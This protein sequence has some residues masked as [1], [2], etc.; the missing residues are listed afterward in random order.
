MFTKTFFKDMAERAIK[1]FAQSFVAILLAGGTGLLDVD[2]VNAL[3]VAG[4]ALVVSVFTSVGSG[5][6]GDKSA[7]A[8][9][10]NKEGDN[11]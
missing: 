6:V 8:V 3:S 11:D 2:W 9:H 1:T 10:L 4:L 5:T 7:S